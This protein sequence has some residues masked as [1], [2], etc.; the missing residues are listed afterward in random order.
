MSIFGLSSK[1]EVEEKEQ[2]AEK[3]GK[4][5]GKEI[6]LKEG[7]EKGLKEGIEKGLKEGIEKGLQEGIEKGLQ[8]GRAAGLQEGKKIGI[9]EGVKSVLQQQQTDLSNIAKGSQFNFTV[10]YFDVF[11]PRF[12]NFAVPV[13]VHG[14]LVYGIDDIDRFKSVNKTENVNDSAF[15]QKLKGSIVKY[16]KTAVTN[17]PIESHIQVLQIERKLLEI[18]EFVQNCIASQVERLFAVN[19]RSLDITD[20]MIDKESIG[21]R[22]LKAVTADV[23]MDYLQAQASLN[24]DSM[25]RQQE[26]KLGG[27]E[28]LQ[29]L[30]LEHQRESMRIQRE[31]LQRASKLQTETNFLAAHQADLNNSVLT[32]QAQNSTTPSGVPASPLTGGIPPM[33]GAVP[34][35]QYMI[36]VNGQQMGPYDWKQLQQLVQQGWLTHQTYVWKQGM[37][38][39]QLAGEV[40]ELLPLFQGCAPQMPTMPQQ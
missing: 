18:S 25:R 24:L 6:G 2:L 8:E 30:Q 11:D 20:I 14:I 26:M 22:K 32:I 13:S 29:R 15:Q 5:Y 36:G 35:V 38:Q 7:R 9:N 3:A 19:I 23:E 10:P 27:Q 37:A 28:E 17:A 34:Q 4:E 1:K 39:W 33:P 12:E 16:I 31:E 21:Y 40:Q